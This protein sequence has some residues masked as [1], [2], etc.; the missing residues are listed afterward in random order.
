M[1]LHLFFSE[2]KPKKSVVVGLIV[3][4]LLQLQLI[5]FVLYA[6]SYFVIFSGHLVLLSLFILI[7]LIGL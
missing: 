4:K 5:L 6:L 1:P 7:F 3:T 2:M